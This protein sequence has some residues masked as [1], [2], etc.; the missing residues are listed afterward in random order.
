MLNWLRIQN[1][2]L[3]EMADLE[4]GPGFNVITGETGAGKSVLIGGMGLILGERADKSSIRTGAERCEVSAEILLKKELAETV[5]DILTESEIPF[6]AESGQLQIRRVITPSS[7]RNFI[8]DTPV[9]LQKLKALGDILVDIHGAG[10]HQSLLQPGVQ[11]ELVD[12]FGGLEKS[13][14]KCAEICRNIREIK[15]K[16]EKLMAELPSPVEAEHLRMVVEEI[17]KVS[18]E[19]DED[20]ELTERHAMAANSKQI[21]E[22]SSGTVRILNE[23][24]NSIADQFGEV[25]R[26]LQ[27][28][29]KINPEK[30]AP[31][32]ALGDQITEEV[33]ELAYGLEE[34]ASHVELDE[35][36]FRELEERMGAIQALKRRYGPTLDAVFESRDEAN[37]RLEQFD[38]SEEMRDELERAESELVK[39][40]H[41]AAA[42]LSAERR[43]TAK[44]L[45]REVVSQLREL[46]FL[47]SAFEIEFKEIDPG[48]HGSDR[49]EFMFSANPGESRKPLRQVASSG[50]LSRVMLALKT[51]LAAADA[52][53]V[54]IF[55]E[56][57]VNIGGETAVAV[58]RE[59][60]GLASSHQIFCISHLP[61]VAANAH[62]HFQV[63]KSVEKGRTRTYIVILDDDGCETE[64]A[65]M[66]GGG[67]AAR[68]HAAELLNR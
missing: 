20:R 59:L 66:L 18:P 45:S 24:E 42:K 2:A 58:G 32:V 5:A 47:N 48:P 38:H 60:A 36:E 41:A 21:L 26:H 40:L 63:S 65:R 1:L 37:N 52:V 56:I 7:T 43:K 8:N 9:T 16:R 54:L 15:E 33:R 4:F 28:L 25:Y 14:G 27:E 13:C 49:I 23:S 19:P 61:Q 31:L 22:V 53:P 12:R 10:E 51:V 50:E 11:L 3:I 44:K 29:E 55:D 30:A 57:D 39:Q 6:D 62:R 46:G 35:Q 17:G 64:I 68:R 67:K 34:F